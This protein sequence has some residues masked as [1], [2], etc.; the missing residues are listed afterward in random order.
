M[1]WDYRQ[2]VDMRDVL[3]VHVA[4]TGGERRERDALFQSPPLMLIA[5][6]DEVPFE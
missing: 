2:L 1:G 4:G 6:T 3:V 5:P